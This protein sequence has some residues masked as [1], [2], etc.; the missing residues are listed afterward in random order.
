MMQRGGG[1]EDQAGSEPSA[2]E[3]P[4]TLGIEKMTPKPSYTTGIPMLLW[5]LDFDMCM[6]FDGPIYGSAQCF[7]KVAV[8][9]LRV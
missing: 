9:K 2:F 7:E 8:F 6:I 5:W 4:V 1:A 3:L